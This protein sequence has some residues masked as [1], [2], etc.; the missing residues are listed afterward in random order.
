MGK[1]GVFPH[2]FNL[3]TNSGY[4]GPL[5]G[6]EY[7]G[8]DGMKEPVRSELICWYKELIFYKLL[9]TDEYTLRA[10]YLL[11][12]GVFSKKMAVSTSTQHKFC[13][14]ILCYN[15]HTSRTL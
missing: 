4:D 14:S 13:N 5:P 15:S 1:K 7:Y 12:R 6:L 2:L 10:S 8:P 9:N 3:M 11:G